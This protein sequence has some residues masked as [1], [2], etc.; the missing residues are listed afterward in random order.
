VPVV[1]PEN[2]REQQMALTFSC[3]ALFAAATL[4]PPSISA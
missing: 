4:R 3:S 1:D 2:A